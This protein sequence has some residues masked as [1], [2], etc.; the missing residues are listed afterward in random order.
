LIGNGSRLVLITTDLIAIMLMIPITLY[1]F[2]GRLGKRM[3]LLYVAVL[4]SMIFNA[5]GRFLVF[6][7]ARMVLAV[8]AF[9][10]ALVG[11]GSILLELW[12]RKQRR[13]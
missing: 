13:L 4:S 12:D 10:A 7:K 5:L 8:V 2:R 6:P 3:L 9:A 11:L 1:A